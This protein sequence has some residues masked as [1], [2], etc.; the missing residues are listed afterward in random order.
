M[1][2]YVSIRGRL[3]RDATRLAAVQEIVATYDDDHDSNGWSCPRQQANWTHHVFYGADIRE[4]ALDWFTD[5]INEIAGSPPPTTTET[6]S[7]ACSWSATRP[8]A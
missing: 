2:T 8:R 1:G 4:S 6:S 7:R 5:R 3:E